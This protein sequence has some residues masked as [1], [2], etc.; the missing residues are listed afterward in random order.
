M[1]EQWITKKFCK[2]CEEEGE[3][4]DCEPHHIQAMQEIG[5]GSYA[6]AEEAFEWEGHVRDQ[7]K[8]A[9]E[10]VESCWD[11]S[12]LPSVLT[13]HIDW[14]G[15]ADDMLMDYYEVR[16]KDNKDYIYLYRAC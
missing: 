12:Y 6:D 11:L 3:D 8:W 16:D 15:V 4:C 14:R 9:Y 10:F 1:S 5:F 7:N 13:A 2:H